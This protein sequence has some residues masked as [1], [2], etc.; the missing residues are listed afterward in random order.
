MTTALFAC[1]VPPST[2]CLGK[3]VL[4]SDFVSVITSK[5]EVSMTSLDDQSSC[6]TL[7][8]ICLS[9]TQL[10]KVEF[11]DT[12]LILISRLECVV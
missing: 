5:G 11:L 7:N 6:Y 8:T 12:W 9:F 2:S 4:P 1:L 3:A 10:N